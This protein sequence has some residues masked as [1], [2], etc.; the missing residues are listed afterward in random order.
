MSNI[1]NKLNRMSK[2]ATRIE[3]NYTRLKSELTSELNNSEK[4][5]IL[6][7]KN[8]ADVMQ[9]KDELVDVT[10]TLSTGKIK[11]RPEYFIKKHFERGKNIAFTELY[12][13]MSIEDFVT[14]LAPQD[15]KKVISNL[16]HEYKR[17]E[18]KSSILGYLTPA[19]KKL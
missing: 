19:E 9:S 14:N 6:L 10:Y 11:Q 13:D 3:E 16:S 2:D 7:L 5:N 12:K 18:F 15:V 17:E 1:I 8:I 4:D